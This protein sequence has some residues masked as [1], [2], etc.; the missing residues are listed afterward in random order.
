MRCGEI[1]DG[2]ALVFMKIKENGLDADDAYLSPLVGEKGG[3]PIVLGGDGN[4][5][6]GIHT[7]TLPKAYVMP[8][9][10]PTSIGVI[11]WKAPR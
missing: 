7:Q 2:V 10:S 11:S 3:T 6:I 1:L 8:A 4:F 9:G 5:L